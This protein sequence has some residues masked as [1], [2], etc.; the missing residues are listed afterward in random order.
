MKTLPT[1]SLLFALALT[2][3]CA[4]KAPPPAV[5]NA[6]VS[7]PEAATVTPTDEK[8]AADALVRNFQR[9]FFSTDS[10]TLTTDS[11]DALR[12]NA[13][14]LKTFPRIQIEV[15]GH[16]DERGTIDYNLALGQRRG[17]AVL[18]FLNAEGVAPSRV[19][20]VSYGEE[21]PLDSGSSQSAWAKNRRAE[22]RVITP[23]PA[24]VGTVTSTG[25]PVGEP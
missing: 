3:A 9:V 13:M 1:V 12:E 24:V 15:Q 25:K 6:G 16:A 11:Q 22:F 17:K 4:K 7:S 21:R 19:A 20:I 8:S 5:A 10:S 23:E 2:P 14:I 18:D